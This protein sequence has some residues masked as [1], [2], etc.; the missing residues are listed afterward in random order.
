LKSNSEPSSGGGNAKY[1]EP[2]AI[3]GMGGVFPGAS[4]LADF[5][6]LIEEGRDTCRTVPAGRWLLDPEAIQCPVPGTPDA[7]LTNRGC[8]IEDLSLAGE[9]DPMFQLLIRA[10]RAAFAD[11][12]TENLKRGDVGVVLG[13]IAL[14]TADASALADEVL[15]PLFEQRV[16]G[17]TQKK[18]SLVTNALNRYVTGLPANLLA[19]SLGL[20]GA[21]F[22]LDAACA[23]SLYAVKLACDELLAHRAS[24]MLAGGLSRPDSLYTQMGFS[25]LRALSPSGRCSPFDH[26][27]DGLIVGEGAGVVLLKRLDDALRDGDRILAL[28]RGVGLSNDLEGNLLAPSSEGQLRALHSAYAQAGWTPQMVDLIECHATGTPVGDA[29]EFESLARLWGGGQWRSGQCV[30]SAVKSNIGHLLT[31]A[32]SA[33][34]IKT[35]LAMQ[36]GKLP[37]VANFERPSGKV[38][39]EGSPFE[40]LKES[41][42]WRRRAADVPRRA[43]ING[44]GFGGINAH[45][46]IE[47]WI[48]QSS[49]QPARAIPPPEPVAVVGMATRLGRWPDLDAFQ[50]RVLYGGDGETPAERRDWRGLSSDQIRRV[51]GRGFPGYFLDDLSIPIERFHIAPRELAEMLPQQLLMLDVAKSALD[52]ARSPKS[53]P[54]KLD[55]SRSGVFIGLSLDLRTTDFHFRWTMKQRAAEWA[56]TAGLDAG[57]AEARQWMERLCDGAGPPLTADRTLGALG[58]I[59]ASRIARE[60]HIGGPSHSISSEE[61]SGLRALEVAMR[62]LQ[63]HELDVALAGAVD[64]NGDLRSLLTTDAKGTVPG[65]GAA[66]VVLKR[67]G[68]AQRDGDRIYAVIRDIGAAASSASVQ[69]VEDAAADVGHTGAASGLV[70]LVK[71]SLC[72][73]HEVIPG[74]RAGGAPQYWVRNRTDGPRRTVVG[75]T[76]VA[77]DSLQVVL[78]SSESGQA[79]AAR[80]LPYPDL[81][82]IHS[83]KTA[84]PRSPGRV[85]FVFPGSGNQFGGMGRELAL[86]WPEVLRRQDGD[87]ARLAS[88]MQVDKFWNGPLTAEVLSDHRALICGQLCF[89]SMVADLAAHFG[90]KPDAAIGYSLGESTALVALRAWRQRD[91]ML[92]RLSNSPLFE[93][94]LAGGPEWVAGVVDRSAEAVR[95]AI[96]KRESVYLLISNTPDECVIGGDRGA[97]AQM[98]A[99]LNC[100]WFPLQGVSTVHCEL[101]RP[102]RHA[103]RELHRF[104]T[105]PPPGV[106]FYSCA[107]GRAYV[108]DRETAADAIEAQALD[109][110]DFPRVIRA[111]YDA[112]VRTFIE[113]G[114]GNSCSRM[115]DKILAGRPHLARSLAVAG[116][117]PVAHFLRTLGDLHAAGVPLNVEMLRGGGS[118]AAAAKPAGKCVVVSITGAPFVAPA[119]PA[120]EGQSKVQTEDFNDILQQ[121]MLDT[122]RATVEAHEAYLRFS[123]NLSQTLAQAIATRARL[124]GETAF[125]NV[126]VADAQVPVRSLDRAAC[127]EFARGSV[128]RVLGAEFAE[129]DSF[130]TRVRLPDEPLMLVDRILEV[131]GEPQSMTHGRVVTEHDVRAGAWYLDCGKIPTCIAVEAGQADLFLCGFLGIDFQTRGRSMYR[132]LDAKVC[133]HRGLPGAG[134]VIRYDIRIDG[135]FRQSDTWLFRFGFEA[136]VNG[137]PLLT[138]TDGCAGFFSNEELA[139]GKGIVRTALD[140]RPVLGKRP[141]DWDDFTSGGIESYADGQLDALREGDLAGCFGDAFAGLPLAKPVTLPGGR[142]KLVHRITQLDPAGGR[143]GLGVVVGEADIHRDDWFLTCH[144]VDDR[145]MPGTLMFECCL[146]TLRI[147]LLRQGW[148]V[149]EG[150]AA[151]EP[152]PGVAS[153]LKCRGQVLDTTQRVTYEVSIKEIGYR[154]EPYVIADALMYADGKPI[155]EIIGMS[156]RYSG[157]TKETFRALWATARAPAKKAAIF[158][159]D[160]ILA[161]AVG[162]PSDAFGEPYTIFDQG[163]V[164]ARLPGPPYQ[165]LDRITEIRAEPWKMLPGAECEA[166]YDVPPHA[167]Y[168]AD[169][170]QRDMPFAVLLE[171]ALQPCGWLA[172]YM[173]SA[174]T[175]EID[176]SFRNLGGS[177]T[178]FA[179]VEPGIGTLTVRVK[180]T[181]AS[182]S[183]GMIIQF[184]DYEVLAGRKRIYKGDTYFG[185]FPKIALLKQEGLKDAARYRPGADEIARGRAL[186]FPQGAPFPGGRLRM[187]D[188]IASW[189]PDGGPKGLGFIRA[190]RRVAAEEWFFKAHFHQDPVVPGSLGLESFLQLLRFIASERW[191]N[192]E[193]VQFETVA[194]D[195]RHEW[196]YRGQVIPADRE[197]TVEAIVTAVDDDR[198]LLRADGYLSVDGRVIYAMKDFTLRRIE[199]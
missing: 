76:G 20:G 104:D 197:V 19:Q 95:A 116:P 149:E 78:E 187:L 156:L 119:I 140:L 195:E 11:A 89:G 43:A 52:D 63:K 4:S 152:V 91:E 66:C 39:L 136:T 125:S 57:S 126:A 151:L 88:Q 35:L 145:V 196:I 171:I 70:S 61:T 100:H 108:P 128:G 180:L 65:E 194:T 98:V 56:H 47:E 9:L 121:A 191:G 97:V 111:A 96:G 112:G 173:G 198:R 27:G 150:E 82:I 38:R 2:I 114:P 183:A 124:M 12:R 25:Q 69:R 92:E 37:P 106:E 6:R 144:F 172:A 64:L 148:I 137:A 93:R 105:E 132:L 102:V 110:I 10:G 7:V 62:A 51:W 193:N 103:Y 130:P 179:R 68:D 36:H 190:T 86:Q 80:P 164:I 13:N 24:A 129:A 49:R 26:K 143:F 131:D 3:V 109:T 199:G 16:F 79:R 134:E 30:L 138:M 90:L 23:S 5:W 48:G 34:L 85:A 15:T 59:V 40:I 72:L 83:K 175:S 117:E 74:L 113:V 165:F 118:P 122:E 189:I 1:S 188:R 139:A 192:N 115:I 174:L 123:R 67:L 182:S 127:L 178:Q 159:T 141:A 133:F 84:A 120:R 166:Q 163:R 41:R 71:A 99:A 81:E 55:P 157:A 21:C 28:V 147:F 33:G 155:V 31:A 135:F 186:D 58:G 60:F 162:K 177:A 77:G 44:F 14:P 94:D 181:R 170:R 53:D 42:P 29:V 45:L 184:Y 154:P 185:F 32:G 87:N 73:Y 167:W 17:R 101:A 168:F 22:T 169:N 50:E 142:M 46:L 161:F 146:H 160:R 153:Q 18:P 54:S 8:F 75:S 176:V 107:W 158:D